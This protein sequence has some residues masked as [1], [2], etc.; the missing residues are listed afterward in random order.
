[1]KIWAVFVAGVLFLA[2]TGC[3]RP[4]NAA[5]AA[6]PLEVKVVGVARSDVPI[7]T[8]FI[9]TLDGYVNADIKAQVSGYLI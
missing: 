4:T 1:M 6:P 2:I 5:S 9:G 8:E 7:Y 3:S